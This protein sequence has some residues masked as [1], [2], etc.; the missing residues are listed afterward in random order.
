MPMVN[1]NS[2][3]QTKL[4]LDWIV[5]PFGIIYSGIADKFYIGYSNNP[6]K[7]LKEH[8]QNSSDK[9]TG[10]YKDW[11]LFAV[12]QVSDIEVESIRL[13]RFIKKQKSR[14]LILKLIDPDF[15]PNGI[16]AQL[17]RVQHLRD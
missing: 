15:I 14:N 17:V 13:E 5:F 11:N 12:F 7:R 6:W 1:N 3:N 4:V 9:F 10:K 2:P 8:N 16:L